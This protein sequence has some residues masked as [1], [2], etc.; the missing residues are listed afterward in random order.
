[1]SRENEKIRDKVAG[2]P[3]NP[4]PMESVTALNEGF[5]RLE[6]YRAAKRS[7]NEKKAIRSQR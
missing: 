2:M 1:M 5:F 7:Q 4:V 6:N 3:E